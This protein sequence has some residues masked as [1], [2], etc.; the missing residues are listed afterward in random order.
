MNSQ[1]YPLGIRIYLF[2]YRLLMRQFAF[3][4]A[5]LAGFCLG[6]LRREHLYLVNKIYYDNSKSLHDEEY[7]QRGLRD[8]ERKV[9]NKYFQQAKSLLVAGVGGGR[10]VL[11]LRRIGYAVD[12]FDCNPG[13]VEC[14]NALLKK[15]GFVPDLQYVPEDQC[16]DYARKT[17][18]GVIVGWGVYMHIQGRQ[19]RIRFVQT[20]RSRTREDCPI[21][22]SFFHRSGAEA[23]FKVIATVGNILRRILRREVLEV[24]D[25]LFHFMSVH[26]FTRKEI[27]T[28]L[29]EGGFR[30]NFYS[31]LGEGHAVGTASVRNEMRAVQKLAFGET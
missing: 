31:A 11:A 12:G 4:N 10:E 15:E 26:F 21:L 6:L 28:E 22:L 8:W 17:Y 19:P 29:H 3:F 1:V 7:N 23:R 13:L 20:L 25:D 16:P 18:D 2:S 30:L 5:L 14:A 24:G 9:I 27:E